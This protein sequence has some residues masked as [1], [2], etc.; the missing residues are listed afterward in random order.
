MP[1]DEQE[2]EM[3]TDEQERDY[4][5][6]PSTIRGTTTPA[7]YAAPTDQHVKRLQRTS[8]LR[9]RTRRPPTKL[10]TTS[11]N[12]PAR[13]DHQRPRAQRSRTRRGLTAAEQY[14]TDDP[15]HEETP[16]QPNRTTTDD[17]EHDE[18]P[19]QPN[20]TTTEDPEP[21]EAPYNRRT[22]SYCYLGGRTTYVS[23]EDKQD[24]DFAA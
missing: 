5:R 18:A 21:D 7:R 17:P 3:P 23:L 2:R 12:Y 15:G 6:R 20:R 22:S 8:T 1:T 14:A 4:H 13:H 16:R 9:T 24:K 11:T 19:P 10:R